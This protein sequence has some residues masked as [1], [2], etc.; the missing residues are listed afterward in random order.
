MIHLRRAEPA[1]AMAVARVHVRSWQA[2]YRGLLSD[3]YLDGLRPE[4]R[5]TSYTFGR[6]EHDHPTTIVS[7]EHETICGFATIGPSRDAGTEGIGA[8]HA[9]YVDPEC[10]DTGVGRTL[11]HE[12]RQRLAGQGFEEAALW[13]LVGNVRA[14]RFYRNDGWAADGSRRSDEVWSVTVDEVRYRRTLP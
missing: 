4:D 5:A 1:D 2:A 9:L 3:E 11:V 7:V 14:E 10:W 6:L 8:L 12:A 13:V